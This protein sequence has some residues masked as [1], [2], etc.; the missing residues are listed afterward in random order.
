MDIP[1]PAPAA[2]SPPPGHGRQGF[3]LLWIANAV[4]ANAVALLLGVGGLRSP[5][6]AV[7]LVATLLLAALPLLPPCWRVIGRNGRIGA[8]GATSALLLLAMLGL[9]LLA[10]ALALALVLFGLLCLLL[11]ALGPQQLTQAIAAT[12]SGLLLLLALLPC[13][14]WLGGRSR[15]LDLARRLSRAVAW[16]A[17]CCL[18][19][20]LAFLALWTPGAW[21]GHDPMF[22]ETQR[23][24]AGGR[25][26]VAVRV[27]VAAFR[28]YH[29]QI[30]VATPLLPGALEWWRRIAGPRRAR[31]AELS[32]GAGELLVVFDPQVDGGQHLSIP[33]R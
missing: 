10:L 23:L 20:A 31:E 7:N 32:L 11:G 25:C 26:Y 21:L 22:E 18:L 6:T 14:H 27:N 15:W 28:P 16:A 9:N 8:A 30:M 24:A 19:S 33:L 17:P 1:S 29:M 4:V 3:L 5:S 13:L 2:A 12:P